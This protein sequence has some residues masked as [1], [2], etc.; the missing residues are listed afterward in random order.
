VQN[1]ARGCQFVIRL[2]L[3]QHTTQH[4]A[5]IAD[6]GYARQAS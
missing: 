6:P 5:L 1:I 2:P 4:T 3:A